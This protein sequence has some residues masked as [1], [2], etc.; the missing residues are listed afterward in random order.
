MAMNLTPA[1]IK[2]AYF[3]SIKAFTNNFHNVDCVDAAPLPIRIAVDKMISYGSRDSTIKSKSIADLSITYQDI[4]GLPN[5]ILTL[6]HPWCK[7][8]F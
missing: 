5:D 2:Q 6:I 1:E 4:E 8:R 7:V 3:E